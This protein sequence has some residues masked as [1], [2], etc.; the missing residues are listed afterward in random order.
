MKLPTHQRKAF[1]EAYKRNRERKTK[2]APPKLTVQNFK[3]EK[4]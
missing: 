2:G 3:D 4:K 1:A